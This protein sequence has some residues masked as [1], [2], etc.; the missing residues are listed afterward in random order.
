MGYS[1]NFRIPSNFFQLYHE[2][3]SMNQ[4]KKMKS[5]MPKFNFQHFWFGHIQL[6]Q[7]YCHNQHHTL[8]FNIIIVSSNYIIINQWK[9]TSV[10]IDLYLA[11][12][13]YEPYSFSICTA[14]IGPPVLY[15]RQNKPSK[16]NITFEKSRKPKI[17]SETKHKLPE[18]NVILDQ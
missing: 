3:I 2:V 15:C 1:L 9:N 17:L 8:L 18:C 16:L 4:D 13:P 6:L 7:E 14:I 11:S 5:N 10:R 12:L